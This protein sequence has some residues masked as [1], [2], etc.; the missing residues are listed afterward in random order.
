[1]VFPTNFLWGGALSAHQCEGAYNLG[2]KGLSIADVMRAGS[3]Q[4]QRQ[5]DEKIVEDVYYP[6]H[7]AIDFY[8]HYKEDIAL[9]KEMGFKCLRTSIAWSRIF[10]RGDEAI[11]NEA[12]LQFYDDLF[13]EL[14]RNGIQPII[15]L[16]HFEMPLYLA[17]ELGGWTNR[18]CIDFFYHYAITVMERY[19]DKVKYWMTF[20]E[21]NNQKNIHNDLY[22]WTCS[23]VLYSKYKNSEE[24][25][26]Q[27]VH[28]QLVASAMVVDTARKMNK[29]FMLGC[30]IAMVP[31]Y[32]YSS[33]PKDVMLAQ[34]LMRDRFF[35]TDVHVRGRYPNYI[36]K[37]W[38]RKGY[39]IEVSKEDDEILKKG[40]V[41]YIGISYYMSNTVKEDVCKD[42]QNTL[43]GSSEYSLGNPYVN[44]SKWG[45][46]IDPVGLRFSLSSLYER[47]EK[48]IFVV[49]N[50]FGENDILDADHHCNDDYRIDYLKSH[51]NEIAKAIELDGVDVLGYTPWG[52]I[53]IVSFTTGEM[54]KRYGFIYVDKDNEGKGTLKR[55]KKKS[56]EWYK[57]VI[58][59]NGEV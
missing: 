49:E 21:I 53:D 39:H 37:Q 16:S 44:M 7:C 9:F 52:C 35:F 43:D 55:Y 48:P 14:I 6:N 2:N 45:W 11:A 28:H 1:M 47:Y 4:T 50:G 24:V 32:P 5:I 51:I 59:K 22:G 13:D 8:H 38:Q 25:M 10:P 33:N 41:D 36:L 54:K 15:T 42:I 20:N 56:F 18:K 34:E 19:Q 3:N 31:I 12:G 57:S 27:V 29:G 40:T 30:M 17:N 58:E 46:T 23:G 26:Y